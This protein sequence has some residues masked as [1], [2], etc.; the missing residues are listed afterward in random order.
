MIWGRFVVTAV[1]V[2]SDLGLGTGT[3]S[4]LVSEIFVTLST[5]IDVDTSR[6]CYRSMSVGVDLQL[7]A[8]SERYRLGGLGGFGGVMLDK[9]FQTHLS[10]NPFDVRSVQQIN[11][12]PDHAK[13][14]TI[15]R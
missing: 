9:G 2:V 8:M 3:R 10:F 7:A 12:Y 13:N 15:G 11:S 6:R 5:R 4:W 14:R 1:L